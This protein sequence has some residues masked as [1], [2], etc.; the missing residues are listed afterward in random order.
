MFN[1][2][3][4]G[5][6]VI[7]VLEPKLLEALEPLGITGSPIY[8]KVHSMEKDGLWLDNPSFPL[9]PVGQPKLYTARGEAFCHAHIFIPQGAILSVAAFP[10]K[11]PGLEK[12][13]GLKKIGF[14]YK[15]KPRA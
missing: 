1:Y 10:H 5:K 9:C 6:Q 13:P 11:V 8:A 14:Q 3:L 2:N 12:T 4:K 7:L 15:K